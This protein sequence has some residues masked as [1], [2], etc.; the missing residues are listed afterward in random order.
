[1][2]LDPP[3]N[4]PSLIAFAAVAF[5]QEPQAHES[6]IIP[7]NFTHQDDNARRLE[8]QGSSVLH[9]LFTSKVLLEQHILA[10]HPP[11]PWRSLFWISA[12]ALLSALLYLNVINRSNIPLTFCVALG[13][14][15]LYSLFRIWRAHERHTTWADG[16][17]FSEEL[18]RHDFAIVANRT[19]APIEG[20]CH[21]LAV[22]AAVARC[23]GISISRANG[24]RTTTAGPYTIFKS[25]RASQWNGLI[26]SGAVGYSNKVGTVQSLKEKIAFAKHVADVTLIIVPDQPDAH[27]Q[28]DGPGGEVRPSSTIEAVVSAITLS[29]PL[30]FW[31][32]VFPEVM[33]AVALAFLFFVAPGLCV[34]LSEPVPEMLLKD[35]A[36][37][38]DH[39]S[40]I[41]DYRVFRVPL[42]IEEPTHVTVT[43]RPQIALDEDVQHYKRLKL[44]KLVEEDRNPHQVV[45]NITVPADVPSSVVDQ[46]TIVI[47]PMHLQLLRR[48]PGAA[49]IEIPMSYLSTSLGKPIVNH[50]FRR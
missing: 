48:V 11:Q 39:D 20:G 10:W 40:K 35:G 25:E 2:V 19:T 3:S 41:G 6:F 33:F 26:F 47:Q 28:Y 21:G 1:M 45:I 30:K 13:P 44:D 37:E 22:L 12:M 18:Q 23:I 7:V 34:S 4:T 16:V 27:L 31:G 5:K 8:T 15:A 24:K 43:F 14:I 17:K 49:S 9:L 50:A 46:I 32:R 42:N 38:F 29:P 36:V